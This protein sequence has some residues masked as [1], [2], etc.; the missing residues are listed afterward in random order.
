MIHVSGGIYREVCWEGDWDQ[1]F[2]SGLR[3]AAALASMGQSAQ[4]SGYAAT[5]DVPAVRAAASGVGVD[6][7]IHDAAQ[8]VTFEY[9]HALA[10][11]F[12]IPP[13]HLIVRGQP[14]EVTAKNVLRFGMV[15]GDAVAS[16]ERA[17]Y[18]PQSAYRPA[19]FRANG[20][21]ADHLAVVCNRREAFS[22]TGVDNLE[23]A[24]KAIAE[25][26][27]AAIV[28]VKQGAQ[29]MHV[30]SEGAIHHVPA[31]RTSNVWKIGTGD[32]FSAIFAQ[33]W[34][35]D[36]L[37]PRDAA[38]RASLATAWY[39]DTRALPTIDLLEEFAPPECGTNHK[40]EMVYLAGPFFNM[41][42]RWMIRQARLAL[43]E[44]GMRVF[45][46]LHD[47]G[48]GIAED[49]ATKDLEG[50]EK[51]SAVFAVCDGL[52]SGTLFE[53]G[54]ARKLGIPVVVFV[55]SESE[56]SLKMLAGSGCEI[57]RDFS[58]AVYRLS[59]IVNE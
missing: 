37:P 55:Q 47:V 4:L 35:V 36:G 46:P 27:R 1:L 30:Y 39:C 3:A 42:Q 50:I 33:S 16:C 9:E 19:Y 10:T 2:G 31:F 41:M 23:E 44:S 17:V 14:I 59:W 34:M 49:V 29:G 24:I 52:D 22:L 48:H 58:S 15:D 25:L 38:R 13:L 28:V 12:V 54:Y 32:V 40:R 18:D 21:T 56:E 57:V 51:S 45:S 53:I 7:D 8:T 43:V 5:K 20:S 6:A 11:P 26:D